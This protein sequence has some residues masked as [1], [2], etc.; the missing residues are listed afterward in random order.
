MRT[1]HII[2][3]TYRH[4]GQQVNLRGVRILMS[5]ARRSAT[6]ATAIQMRERNPALG[7]DSIPHDDYEAGFAA[8]Y[9]AIKGTMAMVP[10]SPLEPLTPLNLTPF[11]VGVREGL[12]KAG[13]DLDDRR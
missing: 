6:L 9:Q 8:G 5:D 2:D 4:V 12:K 13:V 3:R 7:E 10:L 11:L 1:P